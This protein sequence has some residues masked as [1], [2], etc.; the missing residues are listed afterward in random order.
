MSGLIFY[1]SGNLYGTATLGGASNGGAAFRL[2][3]DGTYTSLH[4][5]G[6]FSPP[7]PDGSMVVAGLTA[8][9]SG[10]FYGTAQQGGPFGGGVLFKLALDGTYTV[11]HGFSFGGDGFWPLAGVSLDSGGN[12]YGT[13]SQG[14]L[15]ASG[16]VFKCAPD[17]TY[18]VLHNFAFSDGANPLGAVTL[19]SSGNLYGTTSAGGAFNLGNVFKL[20]P[21]GTLTSL[22]DFAQ[23]EGASPRGNLVLD[24]GGSLYGTTFAGGSSN[25]GTVFKL[26]S[27]GTYTLLHSFVG[28][29]GAYPMGGLSLYG[30]ILYGAASAGGPLTGGTIFQIR[31]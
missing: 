7:T 15:S 16:I 29:D 31:P 10:N 6:G 28:K 12:V 5:F 2:G 27:N 13:T 9:G 11:L 14:G 25:L 26:A 20:A 1:G 8:D 3:T 23:A 30:S 19:D 24:S 18:T 21:D 17:G 4:D 22:H